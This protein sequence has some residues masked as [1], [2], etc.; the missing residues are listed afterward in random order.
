MD[1]DRWVTIRN[2]SARRS[3][4]NATTRVLTAAELAQAAR[5]PSAPSAQEAF[6]TAWPTLRAHAS[7]VS[8]GLMVAAV[9][10]EGVVGMMGLRARPRRLVSAIVGRH[11]S[12]DLYVPDDDTLSLR[13]LLVLV[14][15]RPDEGGPVRYRVLDL[16]SGRGLQ[17][18]QRRRVEAI[19]SDGPAFLH[20]GATTLVLLPVQPGD[21]LDRD[22][23]EAWDRLPPRTYHR[24]P[25]DAPAVPAHSGTTAV[26]VVDGPSFIIQLHPREGRLGILRVT[27]PRGSTALA[28]GERAARTGLLLGRYDRCDN[29]GLQ[30]LDDANVSR[31]HLIIVE[32]DGAL[33]AIDT[34]STNGI[35]KDGAAFRERAL[36][37]HDRIEIG[38]GVADVEWLASH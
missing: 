25:V 18:E 1:E 32:A 27:S 30:V 37:A 12:T 35:R 31:V 29:V 28:V 34:G 7:T 13:H 10:K 3:G 4:A 26:Q 24:R 38:H 2:E 15:P 22:P 21:E 20:L 17:D 16:R 19:E 9:D 23:M 11:A 8:P 6:L 36:G 5:E 33:Y 14:L